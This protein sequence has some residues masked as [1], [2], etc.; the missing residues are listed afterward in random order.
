MQIIMI[1]IKSHQRQV[2]KKRREQDKFQQA[3]EGKETCL[4]ALF[5]LCC[6]HIPSK[7]FYSYVIFRYIWN[8]KGKTVSVEP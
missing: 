8:F 3:L 7:K 4:D 6:K 5:V 1:K 2:Y